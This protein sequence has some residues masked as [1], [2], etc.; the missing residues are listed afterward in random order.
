MNIQTAD[1][2]PVLVFKDNKEYSGHVVGFREVEGKGL[3]HIV[4][5]EDGTYRSF[6]PNSSEII[7]QD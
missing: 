2:L 1:N 5:M 6:Y 3:Q 7:F 4:K